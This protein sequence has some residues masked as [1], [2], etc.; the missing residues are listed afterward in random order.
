VD[1]EKLFNAFKLAIERERE[2]HNLYS[3]LALEVEDKGLKELFSEFA[4]HEETHLNTLLERYKAMR[5]P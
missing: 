1:R 4:L 2:A 3:H 5:Q